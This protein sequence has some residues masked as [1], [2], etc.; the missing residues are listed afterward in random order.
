MKSTNK[1]AP[2]AALLALCLAL[3]L[4]TPV[5]A[6]DQVDD[7]IAS[8]LQAWGTHPFGKTPQFKTLGTSVKVFGIGKD[9]GDT[10]STSSPSLVLIN[11]SLNLMG[12]STI[13][14]LNPNGWYCMRTTVSIM[15]NV[16]LRAHCK[17]HLAM[18][19]AGI[20]VLGNNSG[21]RSFK[22]MTV[23]TMGALSV[24]RPCS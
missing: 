21:S 7:S 19:S 24:E 15:G 5:S 20:T 9:T 16:N 4:S 11:P 10:E 13:E 22:D 23:T 12:G 1:T 14:L 6:G 3:P 8:C 2:V 18:T 17:A